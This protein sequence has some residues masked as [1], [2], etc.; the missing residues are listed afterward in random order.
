MV[1]DVA[2]KGMCEKDEAHQR[3]WREWLEKNF[4]EKGKFIERKKESD[5]VLKHI[6]ERK[7]ERKERICASKQKSQEKTFG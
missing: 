6:S 4:N 2:Y 7:D 3:E 1:K 5:S